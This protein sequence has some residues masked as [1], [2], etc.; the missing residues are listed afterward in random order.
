M[1][2]D[3]ETEIVWAERH[4]ECREIDIDG[5][6]RETE[7]WS[8]EGTDRD[9]LGDIEIERRWLETGIVGRDRETNIQ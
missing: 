2:E 9:R 1:E 8:E 7:T 5:L 3:R 6:G 4:T